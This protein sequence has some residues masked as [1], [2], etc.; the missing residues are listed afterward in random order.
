MVSISRLT[1]SSEA[2]A[3]T[4]QTSLLPEIKSTDTEE[5]WRMSC[6]AFA[7]L[8]D[9]G[10]G[11]WQDQNIKDS[12][13]QWSK[14][15]AMTCDHADPLKKAKSLDPLGTPIDYMESCGIFKPMK[16]SE[17]DLCHFYQV[18]VSGDFPKFP[19]PCKPATSNHV[20]C[21][22]RPSLRQQA[23]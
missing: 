18:G 16:T 2:D 9:E 10:F 7:P 11:M 6:P 20:H 22:R 15:D 8:M 19:K 17:F 14:Q 4:S 5:E 12:L 21:P 23:S 3:D 1:A 13:E